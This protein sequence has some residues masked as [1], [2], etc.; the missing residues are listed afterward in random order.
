MTLDNL[1]TILEKQ[2][3]TLELKGDQ[4]GVKGVFYE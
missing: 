1:L 3:V 4:I 2:L